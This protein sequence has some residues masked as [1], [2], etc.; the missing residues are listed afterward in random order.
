[1]QKNVEEILARYFS[2]SF[3]FFLHE[4]GE[5]VFETIIVEFLKV[6]ATIKIGQCLQGVLLFKGG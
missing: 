6:I 1:M 3:F 4:L 2:F 5:K